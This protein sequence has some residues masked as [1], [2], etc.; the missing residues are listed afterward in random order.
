MAGYRTPL[1]IKQILAWADAHHKR[2]GKWPTNTAGRVREAP[3][4][5]WATLSQ[6]LRIGRRGLPRGGSLAQL[7]AKHGRKRSRHTLPR[8]SNKQILAWADA[9][10]KR[11]GKWPT[12]GTGRVHEAPDEKWSALT[13]ALQNGA[14]GLSSGGS[15][16]RLLAKHGRRKNRLAQPRLSIKQVLAWSDAHHSR[17]GQWPKRFSGKVYGTRDETWLRIDRALRYGV[18][19]F[20]G[21]HSLPKLLSERR[22]ARH[23]GKPPPLTVKQILTWADAHHRRTGEWPKRNSG[24][25]YKRSGRP[26]GETWSAINLA[27]IEGKRTLDQTTLL[28]LLAKHRGVRDRLALPRLTLKDILAWADAHRRRT[29]KWPKTTSGAIPRAAGET[30]GR[31]DAAMRCGA[32]WRGARWRGKP[33]SLANILAKYRNKPHHLHVPRLTIKQLLAWADD[34]HRR[35]GRY[36]TKRSGAVRGT[37]GETWKKICFAL[38]KGNRGLRGNTS[39]PRLLEERRGVRNIQRLPRLTIK[40]ILKWADAHHTRTRRWPGALSGS[41]PRSGGEN[42]N[43]IQHT[44]FRGGRGLRSGNTIAKILDRH[45]GVRNSGDLPALRIHQ[46]LRWADS[47]HKRTG[48]WPTNKS[49]ALPQTRGEKWSAI[50][51]CLQTGLRGLPPGSS[52]ARLLSKHR[53]V[54]NRLDLPKLSTK[55]I[56]KW[57][58]AHYKLEKCWPTPRSGKIPGTNGERWKSI[59]R[60]L[61][62]G[63]RGMRGGW[64]LARFLNRYRR[65]ERGL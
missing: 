29:G 23:Y 31:I 40:Q 2:T 22:G 7:L 18:R 19:G 50:H 53:G 3:D 39:L 12:N 10:H 52:L 9:H 62:K 6:A 20:S 36:P 56:L 5:G 25:V 27:L 48:K 54:R 28:R 58:D 55:Q 15:L 35:T 61:T 60:A 14:R 13:Q 45:R 38:V 64:S 17:T 47:H 37:S 26:A 46:I 41:I 32:H 65:P 34:H 49:R 33:T 59:N 8:L 42:W 21:G 16:A 43:G 44:L 1:T 51:C 11:T 24:E 30:W 63:I 57:V 4:E